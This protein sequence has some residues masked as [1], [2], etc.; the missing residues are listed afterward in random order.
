MSILRDAGFYALSAA[1]VIASVC[2]T[3]FTI[4]ACQRW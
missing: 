4:E 2:T 1:L 3:L